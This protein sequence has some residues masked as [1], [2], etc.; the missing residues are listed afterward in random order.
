MARVG[1]STSQKEL[2]DLI[3][4]GKIKP[5]PGADRR[6]QVKDTMMK[7]LKRAEKQGIARLHP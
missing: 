3:D 6:A 4:S 1:E 7:I 5:P 2:W